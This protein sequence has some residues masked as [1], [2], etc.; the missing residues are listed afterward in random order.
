MIVILCCNRSRWCSDQLVKCSRLPVPLLLCIQFEAN[1]EKTFFLGFQ[2]SGTV[3]LL[4][5]GA[6]RL[7]WG[8]QQGLWSLTVRA[9]LWSR[10]DIA[11]I[12]CSLTRC[13]VIFLQNTDE[14]R[15]DWLFSSTGNSGH[16]PEWDE[17][18]PIHF[19][20]HS[21][22]AQ[23]VR[24]LQQMLADKVSKLIHSPCHWMLLSRKRLAS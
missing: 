8:T 18:H 10:F 7:W 12:L 11:H 1:G 23:V 22:G 20:G 14:L 17:D 6:S 5:R 24:V 9:N 16:Y 15:L 4:E 21:A 19:V 13:H 2:G 3:L